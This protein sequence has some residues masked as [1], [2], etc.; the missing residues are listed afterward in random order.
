MV[1]VGFELRQY[2][3]ACCSMACMLPYLK[4]L[5]V[6]WGQAAMTM[7]QLHIVQGDGHAEYR[8]APCSAEPV[9]S[10]P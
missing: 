4:D 9:G 10:G 6:W 2:E 5:I 1:E 3:K 7:E 8:W